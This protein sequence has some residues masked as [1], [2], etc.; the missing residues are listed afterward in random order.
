MNCLPLF[1]SH[2]S[3][4]KSI[5]TLENKAENDA[6]SADSIFPL[7]KK[8]DLKELYLVDDHFSGF[9]Q[10]N[11]N[12]SDLG[13]KLNYGLRLTICDDNQEKSDD[14]LNSNSKIIVFAR[15]L[16]GY[17]RLVKLYTDASTEGFYYEPRTDWGKLKKVWN[18]KDLLM[19]FPFY[20]SYVF[21]NLLTNKICCPDLFSEPFFFEE[22]NDLPFDNIVSAQLKKMNGNIVKSKSIYYS[23]RQ[24]FPAYLTFRCINKRTTLSKP[25]LEHMSS[26]E[27]CFESWEEANG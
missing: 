21:N 26:A 3:F 7:L 15:N 5:L 12:C 9:L 19:A 4:G 24:D 2:F 27:F 13:V 14:S 10:A 20:D 17:K 1:K 6:N 16:N 25:N 8:A 22:D 11:Q 18:D 23:T